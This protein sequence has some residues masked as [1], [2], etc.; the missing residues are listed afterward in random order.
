[1]GLKSFLPK[2]IIFLL[3]REHSC[4]EVGTAEAAQGRGLK[5]EA[6]GLGSLAAGLGSLASRLGEEASWG[7]Q[8]VGLSLLQL[9]GCPKS[10]LGN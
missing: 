7:L 1:L 9:P 5:A 10:Y 3:G 4:G 8:T 6:A 2:C